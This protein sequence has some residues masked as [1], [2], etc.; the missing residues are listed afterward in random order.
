M[1]KILL[2]GCGRDVYRE[3]LLAGVAA[4]HDVVLVQATPPTWQRRYV[5]RAY[6]VDPGDLQELL[7]VARDE[8]VDAV[9]TWREPWVE[10]AAAV[11]NALRL[12]GHPLLSARACRDKHRMRQVWAA[13]GVP[14][15]RSELV[16]DSAR[17][18]RAA[19]E[20]GYPVVVKPRALAAGV[21]VTLARD[22]AELVRAYVVAAGAGLDRLGDGFAGVL[23]EEYLDGP[24]VSVESVL[25]RGGRVHPVAVTRRRTGLPPGFAALGHLVSG[26]G[27]PEQLVEVRRTV[28]AAHAALGLCEGV[29]HAKVRLTARGPRLVEL[30]ARL[31]GNLVPRL[32]Q[33]STGVDLGRAAATVALGEAPVLRPT[34]RRSAGIVFGH[35]D[36]LGHAVA[37]GPDDA[38]CQAALDRAYA[39]MTPVLAGPARPAGD[40]LADHAALADNASLADSAALAGA[41]STGLR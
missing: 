25:T 41:G 37:V 23:V 10:A 21:G 16:G 6:R 34:V 17:A 1:A 3:Y 28:E 19:A 9:L 22:P 2:L 40:A 39:A 13:A 27:Q 15:A 18:Q 33:L 32:V 20:I 30:A 8:S 24:E 12:P 7:R 36:R 38:T 35:P 29:T 4:E 5:T 11:S 31:A 14:S 26:A